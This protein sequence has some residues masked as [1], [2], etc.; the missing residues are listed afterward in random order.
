VGAHFFNYA[1][2]LEFVTQFSGKFLREFFRRVFAMKLIAKLKVIVVA[3]WVCQ[4]SVTVTK[5]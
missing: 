4:K 1:R 3:K 2:K 5:V